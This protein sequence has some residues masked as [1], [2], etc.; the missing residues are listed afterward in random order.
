MK[1]IEHT[2]VEEVLSLQQK[3]KELIKKALQKHRGRRKTAADEL[4]ISERTLYRKIN[5]WMS[6]LTLRS[7]L[8]AVRGSRFRV[9][10]PSR[11]EPRMLNP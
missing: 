10:H 4:G 8:R 9:Q 7:F 3:E 2:K 1:D 5:D 6:R 11:P